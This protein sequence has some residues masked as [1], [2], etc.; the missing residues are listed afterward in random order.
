MEVTGEAVKVSFLA[1]RR[2]HEDEHRYGR[3]RRVLERSAIADTLV[4]IIGNTA[5]NL[6]VGELVVL[7]LE[8]GMIRLTPS[9]RFAS[10]PV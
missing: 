10:Q 7:P 8:F 5:K 6:W 2:G 1:P 4:S 3:V 9:V